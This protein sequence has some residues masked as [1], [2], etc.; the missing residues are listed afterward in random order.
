[1]ENLILFLEKWQTLLG[2]IIGGVFAL[3]VALIVANKVKRNEEISSAMLIVGD[4][5][6]VNSAVFAL[7]K[8]A[9]RD[10]ISTQ[11]YPAWITTK[12][13]QHTCPKQSSLFEVSMARIMSV[14]P[15]LAAHL[16]IFKTMYEEME[17]MLGKESKDCNLINKTFFQSAKHADYAVYFLNKLV[18]SNFSTFNKI[19]MN[20]FLL[21]KEKESK[22]LLKTAEY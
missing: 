19:R 1:M 22:R 5:A 12:L 14:N 2:S 10:S 16:K 20:I 11:D 17:R 3:F 7:E 18:L 4:L 9:K 6:L 13:A 15:F 21:S 8:L